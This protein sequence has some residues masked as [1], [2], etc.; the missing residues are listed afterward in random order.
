MD[1]EP[2]LWQMGFLGFH[3]V[4]ILA[5]SILSGSCSI[6]SARLGARIASDQGSVGKEQL[7]TPPTPGESPGLSEG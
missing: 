2:F 4:A 6:Y 3:N 1:M 7:C 5:Y